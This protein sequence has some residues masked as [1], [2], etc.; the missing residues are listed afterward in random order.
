MLYTI[1]NERRSIMYERRST[2]YERHLTI[3]IEFIN[4]RSITKTFSLIREK[5]VDYITKIRKF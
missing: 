2:M 3:Y 4:M 1:N 5:I